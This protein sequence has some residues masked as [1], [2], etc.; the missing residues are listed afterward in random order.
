MSIIC[1]TILASNAEEYQKQMKK[2]QDFAKRIQIDLKDNKF[3]LGESMPLKDIW[4]PQNIVADVHIMYESPQIYLDTVVLI[5][6]NM[7]IVHAESDCDIPKFAADLRAEGI[8]TGLAVLQKTTVQEVAY[9]LPHVQHLLIF[10]GDLGKFGGMAD[11]SL[12]SKI[13]SAKEVNPHLE[14]GWDGGINDQ[15]A[16]EL[17]K[18]GVDV[19][20]VGG[21]LQN[22]ENPQEA[23]AKI[24]SSIVGTPKENEGI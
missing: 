9:I 21:Y 13:D 5:K 2:V 16:S 8:K 12:I 11:M 24:K 18:A 22:S 14:F 20:N 23:Y 4:W 3:A 10:S 17:A 19:L 1:P 15:N 7:A 6:P